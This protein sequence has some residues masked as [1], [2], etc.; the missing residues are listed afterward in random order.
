MQITAGLTLGLLAWD[1]HNHVMAA[2]HYKEAL[3]LMATHPPLNQI[4]PVKSHLI[5]D[6]HHTLCDTSFC[7]LQQLVTMPCWQ[8]IS[9]DIGHKGELSHL[10][11]FPLNKVPSLNHIAPR[12]AL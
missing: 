11:D 5:R 7:I 12:I 6:M 10:C 4:V 2:K 1:N 3:D 8:N 9:I